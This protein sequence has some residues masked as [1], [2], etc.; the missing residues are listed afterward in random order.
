MV[1]CEIDPVLFIHLLTTDNFRQ[2]EHRIIVTY[3]TQLITSWSNLYL[4]PLIH[5]PIQVRQSLLG[6]GGGLQAAHDWTYGWIL[7]KR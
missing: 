7:P 2:T 1:S 3:L 5:A 6:T 4:L